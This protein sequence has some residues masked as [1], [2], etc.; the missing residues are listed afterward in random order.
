MTIELSRRAVA[1]L[2]AAALFAEKKYCVKS[3]LRG[4]CIRTG[5]DASSVRI[6]ATDAHALFTGKAPASGVE[7]ALVSPLVLNAKEVSAALKKLGREGLS[8]SWTDDARFAQL[9]ATGE[10]STCFVEIIGRQFPDC[11][12][13]LRYTSPSEEEAAPVVPFNVEFFEKVVKATKILR[14]DSQGRSRKKLVLMPERAGRE[15]CYAIDHDA[16]ALV[17]CMRSGV[18]EYRYEDVRADLIGLY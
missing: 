8:L 14:K 10:D 3:F 9:S 7:G 1:H 13:V 4:I 17:M 5:N 12:R 15:A 18:G 16:V 6:E 11:D 2:E